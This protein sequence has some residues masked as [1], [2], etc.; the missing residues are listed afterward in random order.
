MKRVKLVFTLGISDFKARY[1]GTVLGGLWAFVLPVVTVLLYLFVYTAVLGADRIVGVPYALYLICGAVP[2]FFMT[3]AWTGMT[4][5]YRDYAYLIR[6]VQFPRDI[7]PS[8]RL[9]AAFVVHFFFLL[10]AWGIAWGFGFSPRPENFWLIYFLA[11]A[12]VYA[13]AVGGLFAVLCAAVKD[14]AQ[15]V[16]VFLQL[17]FWILPI[18]WNGQNLS[19]GLRLLVYANPLCYLVEGYRTAFLGGRIDGGYTVY[20][21][22]VTLLL[23][24]LQGWMKRKI[25]PQLPDLL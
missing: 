12:G 4:T 5:V 24:G 11:A 2:W 8:V 22:A 21:W 10:L 19:G 18:F 13:Y 9:V 17:G 3:D 7:L 20:F 16:Q 1:A 25:L 14:I 23:L 6:K 15:A